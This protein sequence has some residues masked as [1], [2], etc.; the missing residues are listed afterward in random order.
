[1]EMVIAKG[2]I[3]AKVKHDEAVK[4]NPHKARMLKLGKS[5]VL[6]LE[7]TTAQSCKKKMLERELR[8]GVLWVGKVDWFHAH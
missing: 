1:M 2:K 7:T 4:L 6:K 3:D 5:L 8:D